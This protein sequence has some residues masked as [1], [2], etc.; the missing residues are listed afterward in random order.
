MA[1]ASWLPRF[2]IASV[3][4]SFS[5]SVFP[6]FSLCLHTNPSSSP[7]VVERRAI[8]RAELAAMLPAD[9]TIVLEI[10]SGHGHFLARY[11]AE[12]PARALRRR[13]LDRRAHRAREEK[14]HPCQARELSLHPC[15]GP[16]ADRCAAGRRDVRRGL[17]AVSRPPGRRSVT[18][19]T[20]SCSR[21]S[22]NSSP[23]GRGQG[24]GS[25]SGPIMLNTSSGSSRGC[26]A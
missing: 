4:R 20:A 22:S 17:G 21:R 14:G 23:A 6:S 13:R 8:L 26:P 7:H 24:P 5:H 10:G 9:A 18:T 1:N 2:G 11:A 3:F 15:R 12:H 16:G 25:T 19:R